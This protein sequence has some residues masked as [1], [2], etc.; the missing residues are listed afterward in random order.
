MKED[1]FD[2]AE[3]EKRGLCNGGQ[4][5]YGGKLMDA[6]HGCLNSEKITGVESELCKESWGASASDSG[7]DLHRM[8]EDLTAFHT[9]LEK[10]A[11]KS[12][13]ATFVIL[14]NI[15]TDGVPSK[16]YKPGR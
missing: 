11:V 10:H 16:F 9:W 2:D 4:C 13:F 12:P 14:H 5:Q 7:V 1:A 15:V 3:L 8:R 6:L